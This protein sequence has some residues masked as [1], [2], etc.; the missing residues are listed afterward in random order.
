MEFQTVR[1]IGEAEDY[2]KDDFK[3]HLEQVWSMIIAPKIKKLIGALYV[4]NELQ[5]ERACSRASCKI[6]ASF[7]RNTSQTSM[8]EP[9]RETG[10]NCSLTHLFCIPE[11]LQRGCW[12]SASDTGDSNAGLGLPVE[13][14]RK[15]VHAVP[16]R[17][18]PSKHVVSEPTASLHIQQSRSAPSLFSIDLRNSAFHDCLS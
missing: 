14:A 12:G 10:N 3:C 4:Q 8:H 1:R 6:N 13:L 7:K 5:M 17:V 18:R 11:A 9:Q 15:S 2:Q 16:K